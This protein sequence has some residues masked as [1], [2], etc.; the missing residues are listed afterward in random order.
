MTTTNDVPSTN[1]Y[2]YIKQQLS[3]FKLK[4]HKS[5]ET[6]IKLFPSGECR[7]DKFRRTTI[8]LCFYGHFS[9]NKYIVCT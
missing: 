5:Y 1:T 9:R 7:L 2:T 3:N 6:L 4:T 8:N